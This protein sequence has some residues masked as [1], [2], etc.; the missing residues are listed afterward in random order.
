MCSRYH[1]FDYSF[2]TNKRTC[3]YIKQMLTINI[4][5][6]I[7][8]RTEVDDEIWDRKVIT[9]PEHKYVLIGSEYHQYLRSQL[10]YTFTQRLRRCFLLHTSALKETV[11]QS[12]PS[13]YIQ[14]YR[15]SI[16]TLA[17]HLKRQ[18][19]NLPRHSAFKESDNLQRHS[20]FKETVIFEVSQPT[21]IVY[22][23]GSWLS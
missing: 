14:R 20:A 18:S 23:Q 17:V 16:C 11:Y 7:A 12:A 6:I 1:L 2:Y 4:Y 10:Q 19:D 21:S 3:S 13:K 5:I 22:S 8:N 9:W 15:L